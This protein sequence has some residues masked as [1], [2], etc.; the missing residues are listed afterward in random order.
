MHDVKGGFWQMC[1]SCTIPC[2]AAK[3][4]RVEVLICNAALDVCLLQDARK[5]RS[6]ELDRK[7]FAVVGVGIGVGVGVG[8][9]RCLLSSYRVPTAAFW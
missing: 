3:G 9:I 5:S 1:Q 4:R 8:E 7:C 6:Q 2:F